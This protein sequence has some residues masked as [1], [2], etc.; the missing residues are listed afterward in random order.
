MRDSNMSALIV[1]VLAIGIAAPA[2][3]QPVPGRVNAVQDCWTNDINAFPNNVRAEAYSFPGGTI[4]TI[5]FTWQHKIL[6]PCTAYLA[7]VFAFECVDGNPPLEMVP[8]FTSAVTSF[9][10]VN[11]TPGAIEQLFA[12]TVPASSFP[13]GTYDWT[14]VVE[15]NDTNGQLVMPDGDVDDLCG[16]NMGVAPII[17]GPVIFGPEPITF[18]DPNP[19]GSPIG[20]VPGE[21]GTTRPWCFEVTPVVP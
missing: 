12:L 18:L 16:V 6:N 7:Q 19:G 17:D 11:P 4:G 9:G 15:C 14:V 10:A 2:T 20:R 1:I 3:S 8:L 21:D 5:D 13:T